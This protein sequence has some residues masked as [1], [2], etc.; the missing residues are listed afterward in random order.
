LKKWEWPGDEAN[1]RIIYTHPIAN[2][3]LPTCTPIKPLVARQL[4]MNAYSC[5]IA[6][7]STCIEKGRKIKKKTITHTYT[8][9]TSLYMYVAQGSR[10]LSFLSLYMCMDIRP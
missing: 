10:L 5:V 6:E 2:N 3:S 1:P 4:Q 9:T 7:I 8:Y